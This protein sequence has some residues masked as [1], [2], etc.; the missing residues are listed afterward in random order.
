MTARLKWHA[1]RRLP[2]CWRQNTWTSRA[3]VRKLASDAHN[4]RCQNHR[5]RSE[6]HCIVIIMGI[7]VCLAKRLLY[8]LDTAG[9]SAGKPVAIPSSIG[10]VARRP[11]IQYL[12]L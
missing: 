4:R 10:R 3:N 9:R 1:A 12:V 5:R 8:G 11:K 6:F 2:R 7:P